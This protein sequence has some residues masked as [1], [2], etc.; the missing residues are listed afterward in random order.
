MR[1]LLIMLT[2]V[3]L[4]LLG[5]VSVS[6]GET[7]SMGC[8]LG[9]IT[10]SRADGNT[11]ILQTTDNAWWP[12]RHTLF[13]IEPE[14]GYKSIITKS[15]KWGCS[16][17]L[18]SMGFSIL[19]AA[20][21][22]KEP[23]PLD[24]DIS[25]FEFGPELL[26]NCANVDEAIQMLKKFKYTDP[27]W[28]RNLIMAD[29][30]GVIAIAEISN[31]TTNIETYTKDGYVVR[32]NHW[33]SDKMALLGTKEVGFVCDRYN[34]G[35]EWFE[36][37]NKDTSTFRVEDLFD[38][39]AYVY[40]PRQGNQT[41]GPG[42]VLAIEPKK[43]IFWFTYG[44]PGGNLPTKELENWQTNQDMTWGVYIPFELKELPPGQ[45]TTEIGHLTPLAIQ[46]L[47]SHFSPELQRSPNWYK[48]QS[49][50]PLKPFY[51]PAEDVASPNPYTSKENPYSPAGKPGTWTVEEGFIP[52][53]TE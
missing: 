38:Y 28:T 22:S 50:D 44:N 7:F 35:L 43:G 4:I 17:G 23:L 5:A 10:G 39:A 33:I 40:A 3:S 31:Q 45:Y 36:V 9:G 6:M 26:K 25:M 52:A 24:G 48:Y 19:V 14:Y 8:T 16:N 27:M 15:G 32:T 46:Y 47:Y 53:P 34:R 30:E 13:V 11:F 37:V 42:A 18:N 21:G 49:V 51:K 1:K 29:A 41:G 2:L 12:T 20:V